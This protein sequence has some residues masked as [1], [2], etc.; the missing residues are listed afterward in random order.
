VTSLGVAQTLAAVIPEHAVVDESGFRLASIRTRMPPRDWLADRRRHRRRVAAGHWCCHCST[1]P[2][3]YQS[4][5]RRLGSL[6]D[7][8]SLDAGPR[9]S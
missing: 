9:E 3:G 7:P 5:G 4:R 6:Y 2:A 8:S 1:R